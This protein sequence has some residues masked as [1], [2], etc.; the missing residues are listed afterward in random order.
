VSSATLRAE[1]ARLADMGYLYK[2]HSSSGRVPST[3]GIRFYLNEQFHEDTPDRVREAKAKE[4]IFQ[5]RFDKNKFIREA[6]KALSE[7]SHLVSIS[8][9]DDM[10]F[11]SGIGQLLTH[12]DFEDILMLQKALEIVESESILASIFNKYR[13]RSDLKILIG[14]EIGLDPFSNCSLVYSPFRFFRGQRGFLG[15]IGPRSMSYSQVI[16]A[17]R[18]VARIIEE[19]ITG[20]E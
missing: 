12:R 19:S 14:E 6:V 5:K 17:V 7:W 20:W 3:L 11:Y 1:M 16:P 8:L 9:I 13:T 4:R 10:I 2:E 18:K 15:V